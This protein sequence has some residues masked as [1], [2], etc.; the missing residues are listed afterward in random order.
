VSKII[1]QGGDEKMYDELAP[2]EQTVI[3][4]CFY[5]HQEIFDGE[6]CRFVPNKGWVHSDKRNTLNNCDF[7]ENEEEDDEY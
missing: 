7:E 6:G 1:N 3:G 2:E 5:C 4:Y